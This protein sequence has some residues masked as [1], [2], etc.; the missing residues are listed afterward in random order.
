MIGAYVT[1]CVQQALVK[2]TQLRGPLGAGLKV[3]ATPF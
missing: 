1:F 3:E 2:W